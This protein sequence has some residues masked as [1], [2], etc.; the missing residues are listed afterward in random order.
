MDM[1]HLSY[2]Y[3]I[4]AADEQICSFKHSN[5]T[6]P[7]CTPAARP[8]NKIAPLQACTVTAVDAGSQHTVPILNVMHPQ[9]FSKLQIS[10]AQGCNSLHLCLLPSASAS[11]CSTASGALQWAYTH[12]ITSQHRTKR[13]LIC[14]QQHGA[15]AAFDTS[16]QSFVL[17]L[18]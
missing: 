4:D 8:L 2:D 1:C 11:S 15:A 12:T 5:P 9:A 13:S 7:C 18:Q 6:H 14:P 3:F 10:A 17:R 16:M